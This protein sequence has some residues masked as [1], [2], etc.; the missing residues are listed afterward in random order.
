MHFVKNMITRVVAWKCDICKYTII[1]PQKK[2]FIM[3]YLNED[4]TQ[5]LK[6][7]TMYI[8]INEKNG[9]KYK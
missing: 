7:W 5:A 4:H 6:Y 8:E 9:P 3:A 1:P 2:T